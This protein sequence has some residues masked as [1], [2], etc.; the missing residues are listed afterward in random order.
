MKVYGYPRS[1]NH[2]LMY[3][4]HHSF[5]LPNKGEDYRHLFGGHFAKDADG[6]LKGLPPNPT[7]DVIAIER[8]PLATV[9][10]IWKMRLWFG[11]TRSSDFNEFLTKRYCDSFARNPHI[12]VQVDLDYACAVALGGDTC[13][14]AIPSKPLE[15]HRMYY[16]LLK[17]RCK[18]MVGYETLLSEPS[19]IL[20]EISTIFGLRLICPMLPSKTIGFLSDSV[21]SV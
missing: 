13:F 4:L 8:D 2:L 10:S 5:A 14:E 20:N 18:L 9:G 6:K 15:H 19:R 17:P 1:G 3:A 11:L 7:S 21:L 16:A 12:A